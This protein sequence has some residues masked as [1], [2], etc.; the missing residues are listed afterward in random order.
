[1]RAFRPVLLSFLLHAVLAGACSGEP[2]KADPN[3][4]PAPAGARV[5][6]FEEMAAGAPPGGFV[7]ART[8]K[9]GPGRWE[10]VA[11]DGAPSG[12]KAL[13]QTSTDATSYR[14]PLAV[15]ERFTAR[16]DASERSD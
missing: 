9:G 8:G 12:G 2:M 3:Q 6:D 11:V 10:V 5:I 1:M 4:P 14:F 7:L 13:A 15:V 16:D